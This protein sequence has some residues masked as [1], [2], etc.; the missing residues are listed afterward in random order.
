MTLLAGYCIIERMNQN[1]LIA[2]VRANGYPTFTARQLKRFREEKVVEVQV[3]H[4][5]FGGTVSLYQAEA[6]LRVLAVCRLLREHRNFN[7]IRFRLW[8]EG[9]SI[10]I[11][12][13]KTSIWSLTPFSAWREP[14]TGH[15]RKTAAFKLARN[16]FNAAWSAARTN[17]TR[18]VL[19]NFNSRKD[20]QWFLNLETQL[21]YGV[22]VDFTRDFLSESESDEQLEEPADI[23]AHGL[24]TKHLR[25]LPGDIT[26]GFQDISDKQ[27]LSWTKLRAVLFAATTE[28]LNLA[29]ERQDVF[30]QMLECLEIM[31]YLG[32]LHRQVRTFIKH[33]AMQALLFCTLLVM[34]QNGYG[35]NLEE[36]SATVR[37]TWPVIKRMQEV[38]ATLQ[39]ELPA[40]AKEIP[41]L[42]TLGKMFVEGTQQERD[43][44]FAHIQHIYQQN[45]EVLDAFWQRH[46]ALKGE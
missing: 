14:T 22:P 29:R 34:E 25:W 42:P 36:I 43:A 30:D 7:V 13:L 3:E 26:K 1:E 4:P 21:L 5:G 17:F 18:K 16:I 11:G 31:G 2:F 33:S 6:G 27:L 45:K 8:L 41:P 40:I 46:P 9:A 10:E 28:E 12:L 44:Y 39:R 23:L 32:K 24:Q 38:R 35:P 37:I 20:Q 19:Q 15:E